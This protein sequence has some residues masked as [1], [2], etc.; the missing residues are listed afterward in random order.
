MAPPPADIHLQTRERDWANV[1]TCHAGDPNAYTWRLQ[2]FTLGEHILAPPPD[3][4]QQHRQRQRQP[5]ATA[6]A[7]SCCGNFGLVGTDA[8]RV[9]RYN[10]Q[11]GLHRGTYWRKGDQ[12]EIGSKL[13]TRY[14]FINTVM[15]AMVVN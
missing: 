1:L 9:D 6:V 14:L 5:A 3:P 12:G 11:S 8:G 4:Q 15:C 10:L 13:C 2:N 7:V